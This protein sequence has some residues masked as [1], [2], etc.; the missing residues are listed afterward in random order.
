[1]NLTINGRQVTVDDS[2]Q[3]LSREEQDATVEEIASSLPSD[4]KPSGA[5]AGFQ[6]GLK[7]ALVDGPAETLKQF[8]GVGPGRKDD[9]NYKGTDFFGSSASP[10]DWNYSQLPQILAENAPS[11]G[12]GAA[13]AAGGAKTAKTAGAGKKAQMLSA[14]IAAGLYGF[15]SSA[16]DTAKE[17]AV[18]RTGDANAETNTSDKVKGGLTA[19]AASAVGALAPTRFIPGMNKLNTVGT[20]GA[21]DATK[22]YLGTT[23]IGAGSGAGSDVIT[24]AGTKLGTDAE[25]DLNRVANAGL[26][27]GLTSGSMALPQ[28]AGDSI[29]AGNMREFG[30]D[31][32]EATKNYAT[33]LATAGEGIGGLGNSRR[34]AQAHAMVKSDLSNELREAA[35]GIPLGPDADNALA[36]IKN[37]EPITPK[38]L[39]MIERQAASHPDGANTAYLART[40]RVAQLAQDKGTYK[41]D[42]WAGGISGAFDANIGYMLN[43]FRSLTGAAASGL[44]IH[45]LGTS[46][47][48]FAAA[49]FGSYAGARALDGMTGMRSPAKSFADHFADST[50]KL[51]LPTTPQQPPAAPPAPAAASPWGPRPTM[52]GPTGPQ[53]PPQAAP[54]G[55]QGPWGPR[56]GLGVN[57]TGPVAGPRQGP[58]APPKQPWATP[59]VREEWKT[60]K[61]SN[62]AMPALDTIVKPQ[63]TEVP[64][65]ALVKAKRLMSG[66]KQVQKIKDASLKP[67]GA[68]AS[69][70]AAAA[71][72]VTSMADILRN[73]TA[74]VP[75]RKKIKKANGKVETEEAPAA[76]SEPSPFEPFPPEMLYP[77]GISAKAYAIREG[78]QYGAKSPGYLL[79]AERSEQARIDAADELKQAYPEFVHAIAG[80]HR[81]LQRVGTKPDAIRSAVNHYAGLLTGSPRGD[82]AAKAIKEAFI[83]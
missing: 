41:N 71:P 47:P 5:A 65:D 3:N 23:A 83:K 29:R 68:A 73:V 43:P 2:F 45:L 74:D 8:A 36:R 20:Q 50:A 57:P 51:R 31:N 34:D 72:S 49:A 64:N 66:L 17:A 14:L 77:E 61:V 79:K 28:L 37:D 38:E 67:T 7:D 39:E 15:G 76:Q 55:P 42:R 82:A 69:L 78:S 44:G 81:Q 60:P 25:I 26:A 56:P 70:G 16:G 10:K 32:A 24:Q 1:M 58:P 54:Q 12:A 63:P 53:V 19:A 80:L 46:S 11:L 35:R 27:G 21:L 30:G 22:R 62:P 40:L 18:A 33:R 9:P 52:S 6:R 59:R 48:Q 4:Q 13:A 75:A